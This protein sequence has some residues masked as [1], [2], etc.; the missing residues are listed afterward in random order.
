M[1]PSPQTVYMRVSDG[2]EF[3]DYRTR[4]AIN[5]ELM[6]QLPVK[7]SYDARI[8]LQTNAEKLIEEDRQRLIKR[9]GQCPRPTDQ[10]GT[11]LPERYVVRCDQTSCYRSEVNPSGLG[12][13][14]NYN[15]TSNVN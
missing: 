9:F 7:S 3:T 10:S 12:D 5:N 2:R 13:G 15:Y 4:C 1:S 6:T 11:M 14:R 8:F